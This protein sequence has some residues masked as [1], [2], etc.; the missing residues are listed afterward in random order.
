MHKEAEMDSSMY[1]KTLL[2]HLKKHDVLRKTVITGPFTGDEALFADGLQIASLQRQAHQWDS[3]PC[4]EEY[5]ESDVELVILGG[6]HISLA[7]YHIALLLKL[8]VTII[9]ERSEYCNTTRFP[10]AQCICG[11]YEQVLARKQDWIR[12]FFVVVTRGHASDEVC[13]K[14]LLQ[15]PHSYIGMIGSKTKVAKTL[16]NL[17]NEGFSEA[18]LQT[19]YAPIG[20][21]IGAVTASEIA[22]SI[23]AQI[24]QRYRT[25]KATVRLDRTLL[26]KQ[27]TE[28]SQIVV[29][30]VEK[31]GSA[32]CE[33]GFQLTL[34]KDRSV[35]GTVG[36]GAIENQAIEDARAMMLD[37]SIHNHIKRYDLTNTEAGTLGMICGGTVS[38]LFQRR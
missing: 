6:G 13:L 12:P 17:R 25:S 31:H 8:A 24:V 11:D 15:Q 30:V 21:D 22:L 23:M 20:L 37:P 35:L 33:I 36:G 27:S 38:L 9:D 3:L 26:R 5:L 18:L 19:V 10:G 34:F 16:D 1:Y 28:E 14:A 2:E 29:R 7:L 32:P 4:L